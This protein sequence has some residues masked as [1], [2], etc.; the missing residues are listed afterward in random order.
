M[1]D[2]DRL[3]KSTLENGTEE[4]PAGLW[5]AVQGRLPSASGRRRIIPILFWGAGAS[6]AAAA[7]IALAVVFSGRDIQRNP[8]DI[9]SGGNGFVAHQITAEETAG[10]TAAAEETYATSA[11][12]ALDITCK[13]SGPSGTADAAA[14]TGTDGASDEAADGYDG[15]TTAG[16]GV[17]ATGADADTDEGYTA[18]DADA[19][20]DEVSAATDADADEDNGA[21]TGNAAGLPETDDFDGEMDLKDRKVQSGSGL[22]FSVHGTASSNTNPNARGSSGPMRAPAA[23]PTTTSITETGE[24]SYMIPITAGVGLKF[25]ITPRWAIGTGVDVSILS[26]NYA[27][28]YRRFNESGVETMTTSFSDIRNT[29]LYLS[30][31]LNV[32]FSI[33]SNHFVDFYAYAGGAVQKCISNKHFMTMP[34]HRIRYS[35]SNGGILLNAGAGLGCEFIIARQVGIYID[36]SLRYHFNVK[37]RAPKSIWTRQPLT[38]GIEVG[39]RVRL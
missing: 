25:A 7:A 16:N 9:A 19:D 10:D 2:F 35:D 12:R 26:R 20:A 5:E 36:P 28:T 29:Q 17:A 1:E 30:V 8:V 24:S 22:S 4:V 39:L 15:Y 37:G 34:E 11:G 6:L 18:T 31:P 14:G 21:G 3:V 27:G 32:Y 33:I 38:A 23:A 13:L